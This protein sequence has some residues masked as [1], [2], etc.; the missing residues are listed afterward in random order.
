MKPATWASSYNVYCKIYIYIHTSFFCATLYLII[1]HLHH[2]FLALASVLVV[3][4]VFVL[5]NRKN[6][7]V[8]THTHHNQPL[9]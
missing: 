8:N 6:T 1:G 4:E 5:Y 2:G 3:S 7:S 9:Q